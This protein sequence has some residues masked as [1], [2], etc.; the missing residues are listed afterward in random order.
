MKVAVMR[1]QNPKEAP[2]RALKGLLLSGLLSGE[3][4]RRNAWVSSSCSGTTTLYHVSQILSSFKWMLSQWTHPVTI[5]E[6]WPSKW[7]PP[8]LTNLLSLQ[9]KDRNKFSQVPARKRRNMFAPFYDRISGGVWAAL[10]TRTSFP[11]TAKIRN[12]ARLCL[13]TTLGNTRSTKER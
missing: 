11:D 7:W 4:M 9:S 1:L 8:F 6:R 2:R 5:E 10:C 3:V 12:I 13:V